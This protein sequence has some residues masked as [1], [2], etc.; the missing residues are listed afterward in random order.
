MSF[1]PSNQ[2]SHGAESA[3]I[4]YSIYPPPPPYCIVQLVHT[5]VA[6]YFPVLISVATLPPIPSPSLGAGLLW[7][8]GTRARKSDIG[9]KQVHSCVLQEAT[10]GLSNSCQPHP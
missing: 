10:K 2:F 9:R 4:R 1:S 6:P 7:L 5:S 3:N 8:V